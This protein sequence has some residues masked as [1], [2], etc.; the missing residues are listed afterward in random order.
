MHERTPCLHG[1]TGQATDCGKGN[2]PASGRSRQDE[3]SAQP[4]TSVSTC[5]RVGLGS[6]MRHYVASPALQGGQHVSA[7]AIRGQSIPLIQPV[8]HSVTTSSFHR[9]SLCR[10]PS[11][12]LTPR[13]VHPRCR[14]L[15]VFYL[16]RFPRFQPRAAEDYGGIGYP[17]HIE[18]AIDLE[19][20]GWARVRQRLRTPRRSRNRRNRPFGPRSDAEV[21]PNLGTDVHGPSWRIN[22]PP[23]HMHHVQCGFRTLWGVTLSRM[24]L[25]PPPRDPTQVHRTS[26][27]H[28]TQGHLTSISHSVRGAYITRERVRGDVRIRRGNCTKEP[29]ETAPRTN[30][31]RIE[32]SEP[33]TTGASQR[34]RAVCPQVSD[35]FT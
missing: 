14:A 19:V 1:K 35:R 21:R 31:P 32:V 30:R 8:S 23:F 29:Y 20:V 5:T 7:V 22:V 26:T 12:H 25:M 13:S 18:G 2:D 24:P 3:E 28:H 4:E 9:S 6:A 10:L 16:R 15:D 34:S 17:R 33:A 27:R 11:G